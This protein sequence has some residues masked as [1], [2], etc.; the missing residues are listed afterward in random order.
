MENNNNLSKIKNCFEKILNKIEMEKENFK[1]IENSFHFFLRENIDNFNNF[2]FLFEKAQ[3]LFENKKI[4]KK[5]KL[6]KI[7]IIVKS[8]LSFIE[9]EEEELKEHNIQYMLN[10]YETQMKLQHELQ[11]IK[12]ELQKIKNQGD[13]NIKKRKEKLPSEQNP[14]LTS[15]I[16]ELQKKI[17]NGF[18]GKKNNNNSENT[19]NIYKFTNKIFD[20]LTNEILENST[21][22]KEQ[23]TIINNVHNELI[24]KNKNSWKSIDQKWKDIIEYLRNKKNN[25]ITF[26]YESYNKESLKKLL[27]DKLKEI[28]NKKNN[29]SLD[30]KRNISVILSRFAIYNELLK[31]KEQLKKLPNS[32]IYPSRNIINNI[33]TKK[34]SS[35]K[36]DYPSRNIINNISTKKKSSTKNDYPSRT[37]NNISTSV[38][39]I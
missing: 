21:F 4:I 27:E 11:K 37:F 38:S 18:S 7:S 24:Q 22:T 20:N 35:T 31:K 8:I 13:E 26:F 3:K 30:D 2:K 25:E 39:K 10:S 36:N 29:K 14:M 1:E 6:N 34:K 12:N 23:K 32:I 19:T 16:N 15:H 9:E 17:N 33:S 5:N 28:K